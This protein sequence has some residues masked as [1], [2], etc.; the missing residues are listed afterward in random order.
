MP[1][2]PSIGLPRGSTILPRSSS[3]TG[4]S[5]IIPSLLTDES[6]LMFSYFPKTTQAILEGSM[7]RSIPLSPLSNSTSSPYIESVSPSS[8]HIPSDTL[9]TRP[10]WY[11]SVSRESPFRPEMIPFFISSADISGLFMGLLLSLVRRVQRILS[12]VPSYTVSPTLS[13]SPPIHFSS[14]LTRKDIVLPS[15]ATSFS[16]WDLIFSVTAG[17]S[18]NADV[19]VTYKSP[20]LLM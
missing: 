7:E 10:S 9:R 15:A 16:M 8:Q 13:L 18:S 12:M 6:S 2:L 5:A 4:T 19:S 1:P 17:S 20:L 3:P 14:V 11:M